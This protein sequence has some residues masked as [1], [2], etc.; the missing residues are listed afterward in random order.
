LIPTHSR[1]H[2]DTGLYVQ[3]QPRP[4]AASQ[5]SHILPSCDLHQ[6]PASLELYINSCSPPTNIMWDRIFDCITGTGGTGAGSSYGP[7]F[8]RVLTPMKRGWLSFERVPS[9]KD[10]QTRLKLF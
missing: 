3:L 2:S 7:R 4:A 6:P 8:W 1:Q 5:Q 9:R 10:G